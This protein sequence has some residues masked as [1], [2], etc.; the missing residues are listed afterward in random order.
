MRNIVLKTNKTPLML[1]QNWKL[2]KCHP[3]Q[4][5]NYIKY[6][7]LNKEFTDAKFGAVNL[8]TTQEEIRDIKYS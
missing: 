1:E 4:G 3:L 5:N 6:I 7:W 2:I 8:N